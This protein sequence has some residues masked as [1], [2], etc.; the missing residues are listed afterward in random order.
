MRADTLNYLI[1]SLREDELEDMLELT[2]RSYRSD[3][4]TF[5]RIYEN[6]P[7]YSFDLTRVAE[8][9]GSLVSYMRA[10][11]RTIWIGT[12]KVK[13]GGIAEVCTHPD[14][15]KRGIAS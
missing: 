9:D 11:P 4:E 10:A 15:R 6:D 3:V 7:F 14:Y 8:L 1:R 12:A 13:M 2:S 5:R